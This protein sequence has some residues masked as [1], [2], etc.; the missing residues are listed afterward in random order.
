MWPQH[1]RHRGSQAAVRRWDGVRKPINPSQPMAQLSFSGPV[2]Y[3]VFS[4][5]QVADLS[6][7]GGQRL[8][9]FGVFDTVD[10]TISIPVLLRASERRVFWMTGGTTVRPPW[11][12]PACLRLRAMQRWRQASI[13][14][15]G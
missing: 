15:W 4:A 10:P 6:V 13:S 2:T 7:S 8:M 9:P 11:K 12:S 14:F 3:F 1:A 5:P